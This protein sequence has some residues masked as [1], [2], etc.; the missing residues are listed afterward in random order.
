MSPGIERNRSSAPFLE[1]IETALFYPVNWIH[2]ILPAGLAINLSIMINIFLGGIFMYLLCAGRGLSIPSRLICSSLFVFCCPQFMN[3]T[4]GFLSNLS[5]VIWVPLIFLCIDK[6]F[7]GKK[8]W[9]FPGVIAVTMQILSGNVQYVYYTALISVIYFILKVVVE[10]VPLTKAIKIV[11][12]FTAIYS[13]AVVLSSVQLIPSIA[14][15]IESVRGQGV[16]FD[17]AASLSYSPENFLSLISPG[18]FG[19]EVFSPYWGK[20]YL[21]KYSIFIGITGLVLF[22]YGGLRAASS[23]RKL[24]LFMILICAV[25]ALGVYTPLFKLFYRF[26][27]GF[28]LFRGTSKI[29]FLMS[30]FMII[31]AGNGFDR[32]IGRQ[33][34]V[35]GDLKILKKTAVILCIAALLVLALACFIKNP[36]S[37][38]PTSF[39]NS[40]MKN[41]SEA[42]RSFL[43][44]SFHNHPGFIRDT[45]S[46]AAKN[47]I[48]AVAVLMTL[49]IMF[50]FMPKYR[51]LRYLVGILAVLEIFIFARVYRV[52]GNINRSNFPSGMKEFFDSR[53]G[54]YRVFCP[55]NWR[56]NWGMVDGIRFLWGEDGILP[57]KRY[58][59]FMSFTQEISPENATAYIVFKKYSGMYEMLRCRYLVLEKGLNVENYPLVHKGEDYDIYSTNAHLTQVLLVDNWKVIKDRDEIFKAVS[60]PGFQAD[61]EVVLEKSPQLD[62]LPDS[63][64]ISSGKIKINKSSN[65]SLEIS[66]VL[67]RPAVMVI[68]DPYAKGWRALDLTGTPGR[69]YEVMPAN[70]VL[71]AVPLSAGEHN[72]RIEYAPL[73]FRIGKTISIIGL[74]LF[75]IAGSFV[76]IVN[77][78]KA[79]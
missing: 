37:G 77:R 64:R 7:E 15:N 9:M 42:D 79:G 53:P 78:K 40:Y 65:N 76:L 51:R 61:K 68:T 73:S 16:G 11:F 46:Y 36:F 62:R 44:K 56:S 17:F 13:V 71:Q 55:R 60:D 12:F 35:N 50:S 69:R 26:L 25:I 66:A 14:G 3:V 57:L 18:F 54:N 24:N 38:E 10:K 21:W 28:N 67:Q 47:L 59:E 5:A 27:P 52:T 32:L 30:F 58:S 23:N 6:L 63:P 72:I 34:N 8:A 22:V 48:I 19:D 33:D 41:I 39:W 31:L 2:L 20:W 49:S 1:Y 29:L 70:Y 74:L 45:G 4:W 75:A 43:I